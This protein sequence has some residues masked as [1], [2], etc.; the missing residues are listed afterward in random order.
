MFNYTSLALGGEVTKRCWNK[1]K[2][3]HLDGKRKIKAKIAA[4]VG[5]FLSFRKL[6]M[7]HKT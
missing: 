4:C 2:R 1:R 5:T 6:K 3:P 7:S